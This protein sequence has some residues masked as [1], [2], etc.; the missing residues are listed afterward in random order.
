MFTPELVKKCIPA[1]A[2]IRCKL[3]AAP[4]EQAMIHYH[5]D[6][7]ARRALFLAHLAHE[8]GSLKSYSENLNYSAKGLL[9]TFGSKYFTPAQAEE[10]ERQ[11]EKIANR[12][13][14]NRMGNGPES[15]GDGWRYRGV[16]GFQYTGN[17]NHTA[18]AKAF[19]KTKEEFREWAKTDAGAA[20]SAALYWHTNSL[21]VIAD[22]P[23]IWR[24]NRGKLV[25]LD[26]VAYSTAVINGG[27][28]GLVDRIENYNRISK[29]L[30]AL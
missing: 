10:Y 7:P 23:A 22:K 9:A 2:D 13:Y 15:S 11:P 20:W 12:V 14:A 18:A 19:G 8:T 1:A 29:V 25:G 4:L 3:I 17:E 21:N 24:G 30:G 27:Q 16:G 28:I 26:R 6:T 5:I